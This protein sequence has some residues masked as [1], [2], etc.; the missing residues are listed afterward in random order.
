[1]ATELAGLGWRIAMS[2][3]FLAFLLSIASCCGAVTAHAADMPAPYYP[4]PAPVYA[5]PPPAN[6]TGFYIGANGGGA[7]G[8]GCW[9][10]V[11]TVPSGLAG[12]A[13][14]DG[15]HSPVGGLAGGQVGFN[16]QISNSVLGFE[17][18]GNWANLQGQNVSLAFPTTTDRARID[19]LALFTGRIGYTWNSALFYVNGGSALVANKYGFFGTLFGIP[20]SGGGSQTRWGG[21]AGAGLEYKFA[22]NWSA[23]IEYNYVFLDTSRVTFA[24]TLGPSALDDINQNASLLTARV[25]YNFP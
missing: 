8:Q 20:V 2:S 3:N 11:D 22:R 16:W 18:Q 21:T 9:T 14:P 12:P 1:L 15:C 23:A 5:A 25:N 17:A 10:F 24:T 7:W 6:W 4:A 19:G 13:A